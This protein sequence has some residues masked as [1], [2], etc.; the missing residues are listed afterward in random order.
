MR[1]LTKGLYS[2]F[3]TDTTSGPPSPAIMPPSVPTVPV[4][5]T[6]CAMKGVTKTV[7]VYAGGLEVPLFFWKFQKVHMAVTIQTATVTLHAA[8]VTLHAVA[9]T[10]HAM[11]VTTL[12]VLITVVISSN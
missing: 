4:A 2:M 8:T 10:M 7:I 12:V 11:A 5:A 3:L 6:G 1:G 9:A